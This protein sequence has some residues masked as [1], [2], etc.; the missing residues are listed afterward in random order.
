[1]R[2]D[3]EQKEYLI[4]SKQAVH[5]AES[6]G[7]SDDE[8]ECPIRTCFQR[9]RDRIVHSKSF[10]RLKHKTQVFVAPKGDHFRTRLTHTLEVMQIARTIARALSLNEDLT[11]AI[12]LGHDL[13]HTPFGHAGE[14]SLD[15]IVKGFSHNKQSLRV[16]EHLERDGRGLNLTAEVKDGI[17]NHTGEN[18]PFTLEGQIVRLADRIGYVNHDIDDA[19]RAGLL[20]VDCLP[21]APL[22][23]F[24]KSNSERI[25]AMVQDT[26]TSSEASGT[27][28]MSAEGY[29]GLDELRDYLFATVYRRE[30]AVEEESD[31]RLMINELYAYF[32]THPEQMSLDYHDEDESLAVCDYISGMTDLFAYDE[33]ERIKKAL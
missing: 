20:T 23:L 9:D 13:G 26:I 33:Y 25:N 5:A 12:A 15:A 14:R 17:L 2:K 10:R 16:V 30:Q 22:K 18:M 28:T 3:W 32:I 27:I 21:A 24:G 4:L 6:R 11:E 19:L 1:M 31:I 8:E 7:R 29:E